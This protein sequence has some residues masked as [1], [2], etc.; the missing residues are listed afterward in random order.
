VARKEEGPED[1]EDIE[2]KEGKEVAE[3]EED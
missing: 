2:V 3:E 1:G